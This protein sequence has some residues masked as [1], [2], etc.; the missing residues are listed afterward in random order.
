MN[1][2]KTLAILFAVSAFCACDKI[3]GPYITPDES[4]TTDVEFPELDLN[5]VYRKVLIEEYT[6]HRCTNCPD[7]H[8]EL[9]ILKERYGDTLIAIGVHAGTFAKPLGNFTADYQTEEGNTLYAD[10]GVANVGTPAGVVN[11]TQ[12]NNSYALG[13]STWQQAILQQKSQPCVAAI[14]LIN[15]FDAATQTLT[16]HTQTTFL[17]DYN[18]D[19]QIALYVIED[20]IVSPQK[21]GENT[22]DNYVHK[23]VL[24]GSLNGVYGAPM[25]EEIGISSG[26][27]LLKSYQIDCSTKDWNF[28]NCSVIAILMDATTK[29][30]LQVEQA[31]FYE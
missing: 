22:I 5:N 20:N 15:V 10:F 2:K 19:V 27:K 30:V 29:E 17:T 6:G 21:D 13:V 18:S 7:G 25:T 16:A 9:E 23:H 12:Y 1:I 28:A 8:R 24:R 11:R 4:V 14:Q 31:K 26:E 3:E